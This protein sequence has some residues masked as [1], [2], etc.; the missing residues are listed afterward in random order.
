MADTL[1]LFK[2][3]P[4][5]CHPWMKRDYTGRTSKPASRT[6]KPV[7]YYLIDFD[8]SN[9]YPPEDAP[10]F[11]RP[12]WGG[13]KTVPEFLMPNAPPCDPFPVDVYC[14]GN[15]IRRN[16]VDGEENWSK[17]RK[18]FEFIREL[19]SDMVNENPRKRPTM[20]EV[21]SRFDDI[22]KGLSTRQLRSP[23]V[24]V[25]DSPEMFRSIAHWTKQLLY[26]VRRLP[27][28]PRA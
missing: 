3:P 17:A 19:I 25:D 12:P 24:N 5:P 10:H 16:F 14:L 18:G 23:I 8:L 13:D 1:R 15:A 9:F 11:E 20:T 7:K 26:T 21:V 6:R 2:S 4:H 22:V 27:A 28:I